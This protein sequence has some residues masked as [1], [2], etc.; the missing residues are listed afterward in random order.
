MKQRPPRTDWMDI[1]V[2]FLIFAIPSAIL[3]A[4]I[5]ASFTHIKDWALKHSPVGTHE[6]QGWAFACIV[7]LIPIFGVLVLWKLRKANLPLTVPRWLLG[8][9]FTMSMAGQIAYAGGMDAGLSRLIFAALP[10]IAGLGLTEVLLWLVRTIAAK[11]EALPPAPDLVDVPAP[12]RLIPPA[13]VSR[14]PLSPLPT[15]AVSPGTSDGPEG[16]MSRR[17]RVAAGAVSRDMP[18]PGQGDT[19]VVSRP[20]S[21]WATPPVPPLSRPVSPRDMS[22]DSD[23]GV[24]SGQRDIPQV[25]GVVPPPAL[26]E[27]GGDTGVEVLPVQQ[28]EGE[29][30]RGTDDVDVP[31]ED[32]AP[33]RDSDPRDTPG[34]RDSAEGDTDRDRGD[35]PPDP[36]DTKVT[37][38]DIETWT[39]STRGDTRKALAAHYGVSE[40]TI[41]RRL[42]KVRKA[43]EAGH[44]NGNV[45][46]L[47]GA[48][49]GA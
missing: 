34:P 33:Q 10:S 39:R 16:D 22:R 26:P 14:V 23:P 20:V 27:A 24:S 4:S 49:K 48:G 1:G 35:S 47:T 31:L 41:T 2:T 32:P 21:P 46:E 8:T 42:T 45:P 13:P 30:S 38:E 15:L 7:E 5:A 9:G 44:I 18:T 17:D 25:T 40:K 28:P 3:I 43:R 29:V 19:S 6:W 11:G 12:P 36:R 37:K